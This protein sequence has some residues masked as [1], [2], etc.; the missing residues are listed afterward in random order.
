MTNAEELGYNRNIR[1]QEFA[2]NRTL[3]NKVQKVRSLLIFFYIAPLAI[4][5]PAAIFMGLISY[6]VAGALDA[7]I[8]IPL[9]ACFAW[10]GCYRYHDFSLIL[11][12]GLIVLNQLLLMFLSP[13]E[14]KLFYDFDIFSKFSL[15]HMVL[16][17]VIVTTAVINLRMNVIYHKLEESDGFRAPG[18]GCCG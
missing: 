4:Y 2:H 7:L 10:K 11:L 16:L 3:Y 17:A 12:I 14:N 15:M 18:Y 5:L 13:Y 9:A 6:V 1:S 8:V